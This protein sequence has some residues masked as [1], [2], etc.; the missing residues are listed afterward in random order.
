[1]QI[2]ADM[3]KALRAETNAGVL[4]CRKALQESNGDFQKA[5][6][7]LREKGMAT[8][9]KR[10]DREAS[11]G[12]IEMYSH[13]GGRV[14]VMVE[15]NCETDFVARSEQFRT[16]AHEIALQIAANSPRFIK[17]EDIPAAELEREA[18]KARAR[19]KEEA[20][21][22]A[23]IDKIVEGYLDKFK[24]EVCLLRQTYIRD[25]NMTVEKLIMQNV[26]A[27]G[28]NVVVRRFQR[29]ELG[30]STAAA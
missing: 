1:M 7:W 23:V 12:V 26:A 24:D 4:D 13:G 14:G 6:E 28:E 11:N 20:K 21:P 27:I 3:I 30:E 15:V 9:A 18:E 16:L 8:A 25:E 29:W 5:V 22:D 10:A 2:T 17:P 19:G